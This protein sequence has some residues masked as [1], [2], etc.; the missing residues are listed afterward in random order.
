VHVPNFTVSA[1]DKHFRAIADIMTNLVLYSDAAHK[2]R[3]DKLETLLFS[4]DFT[5]LLSAADVIADLQNRLRDAVEA[6]RDQ[7]SRLLGLGEYGR[8]EMLRLKAH[9]LSVAEE[10]TFIFDAIKL[11]Q[12]KSDEHNDQRSALLLHASSNEVA[13][14]MFDASGDLLAKLAV[15]N[16][17]FSWLSRQDSSTVNKLNVGDLQAF[18]GSPKAIWPEILSKH[19]E[20]SNHP[21]LKVCGL[22][23][24]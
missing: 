11:A 14:R 5:D 17:D 15:R 3:S 1:N 7:E 4:Y 19:D 13:W 12:D 23:V 20:P 8:T 6:T 9:T 22:F 21:L 2:T 18:A 10:L 16:I 24:L